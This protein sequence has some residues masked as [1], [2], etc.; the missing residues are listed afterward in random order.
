MIIQELVDTTF[1]AMAASGLQPISPANFDADVHCYVRCA[2]G[3]M[4][5]LE[6]CT[7][8]CADSIRSNAAVQ[9]LMRNHSLAGS[10]TTDGGLL[11]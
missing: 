6:T 11:M 5:G 3:G 8:T 9:Q 2:R 10:G 4:L 1:R 7:S